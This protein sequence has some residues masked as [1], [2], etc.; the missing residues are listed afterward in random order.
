M[1]AIRNLLCLIIL[2]GN[3]Y[4]NSYATDL[5][6]FKTAVATGL[7]RPLTIY[8]NWSAY[9]ELSDNIPQTEELCMKMLDEVIRLKK[10]G[11]QLDCYL[12]D[13]FWFDVDGGYRIWHKQHW[14][15][16]PNRWLN[17][18]KENG[19]IPGLWFSTNLI[20][21][22]GGA[23]L[24]P[25]PEWKGSETSD[26]AVLSLFEGG[27]LNH[28]METL[29][30]Y[31][32]KGFGVFKFD[33]AYFDAATDAAKAT[34][35]PAEIIEANKTAFIQAIKKFRTKNPNV[36]FIGYNGFGGE[37]E[38]TVAPFR[39]T[40]DPRWLEIFDTLYSGDP[41]FSDVPMMNVWRSQDMY[42]DH[43]VQQ[44]AFNGLSL[45][46]IDNCSFMIGETGT[47]YKRGIAAWKS[48]LVLNL[49]RGGWLN[50]YH[51][52]IDLLNDSD[53]RWFAKV[54][55]MYLQ[56][57]QFGQTSIVGGI[58]GK[59]EVYGY[60]A[61][62]ADGCIYTIVNPSQTVRE[63]ELSPDA[64]MEGRLLFTDKG[65][66]PVLKG[67]RLTL[68]TEQMAIVGFGR[69]HSG[70]FDLGIEEDVIIPRRMEQLA[71]VTKKKDEHTVE[72][73][74]KDFEDK[75]RVVFSQLDGNGKPF[76]SWGG[77]L[78]DGA[79]MNEY[80]Q[81]TARQGGKILP[82]QVNYDKVIW[83]GLSW[84]VAEI[85]LKG[86]KTSSPLIITCRAKE[87]DSRNFK[88]DVYDI[89]Y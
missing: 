51:G 25:V 83:S 33:F 46:R 68:G 1:K 11:V 63:I 28:L 6:E 32:D 22:G 29:Q 7:K 52:N 81:I 89:A 4:T 72:L 65:F 47:C 48:S 16:G 36:I 84:G 8:N 69:Y 15:D 39:K 76:R 13:A 21:T 24:N 14:P 57:Q 26:K 71:A 31:A 35:L 3:L 49:A 23:M 60:K 2:A 85:E 9:D 58:P 75:I 27:Y 43:M 70:Q 77:G 42:S 38:N 20:R 78:P 86:L 30:M 73:Q 74:V 41:R 17:K 62:A 59:G 55:K 79:K 87:G 56:L 19:I 37:M 50:V 80:F 18:C 67:G 53:A 45:P 10:L 34:L 44:F 66:I 12:M 5:P 40:V 54:Q 82:V 88:I 64:S 61:D